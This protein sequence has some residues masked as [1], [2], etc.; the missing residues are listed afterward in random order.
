MIA[1]ENPISLIYIIHTR[2]WCSVTFFCFPTHTFQSLSLSFFGVKQ[3]TFILFVKPINF[4]F[5]FHHKFEIEITPIWILHL[6]SPV[7]NN[8]NNFNFSFFT[9]IKLIFFIHIEIYFFHHRAHLGIHMKRDKNKRERVRMWKWGDEEETRKIYIVGDFG[10]GGCERKL[11]NVYRINL[12]NYITDALDVHT[13]I[14][15]NK[16]YPF[17]SL[18]FDTRFNIR[19]FRF[20]FNTHFYANVFFVWEDFHVSM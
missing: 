11:C 19:S 2:S 20:H 14:N 6:I 12:R 16:I 4:S 18:Q 15:L 3:K 9:L 1:S 10:E 17:H 7:H 13:E 5:Y 8:L